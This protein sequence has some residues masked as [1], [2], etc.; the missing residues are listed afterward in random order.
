MTKPDRMFG[1]KDVF[2]TINAMG[3]VVAIC[4]CIDGRPFWAGVA[5]LLGYLCGDTLDGWVARKLGTSNQFGAE[6]DTIADHL[7]HCIAPGAIVYTV[8]RQAD[9]GMVEWQ[10]QVLA[11]ALG[12]AIM[13]TASIRHARNIVQPIE[14]KGIWV[15]L[16]RTVLGFICVAYADANLFHQ[17]LGGLWFGLVLIPAAC[18]AALTHW[19]FPS[20]RM[21]RGHFG[22]VKFFDRADLRHADRVAD[23]APRV[24]LRRAV[25][26]DAR[27][28]ADRVAVDDQGRARRVLGQGPDRARRADGV[29]A[30][31]DR[32]TRGSCAPRLTVRGQ[33]FRNLQ[34]R[35]EEA[36]E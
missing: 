20:H 31:A 8:Y 3:G 4:L 21:A 1:V 6:Y 5:M 35:V 11:I 17:Y 13:V 28:L 34:P 15:G 16:P 2:T 24:H 7:S 29:I 36:G 32:A 25:L 10:Q 18:V 23:L 22:H 14:V 19:P 30:R 12:G 27:L 26:L 33:S 9:L